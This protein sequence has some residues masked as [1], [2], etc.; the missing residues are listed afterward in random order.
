MNV[1]EQ[2][3]SAA[4][5]PTALRKAVA[6]ADIVPLLMCLV[7]LT[8]ETRYF[9][10]LRP[11][12]EG[13]WNYMQSIPDDIQADIRADLIEAIEAKVAS[14]EE[15]PREPPEDL[16]T[17]M[18][19]I[20]CGTRVPEEYM[21]VFREEA[22]FAE[23]DYRRV[24]WRQEPS[25]ETLEQFQ[26]VVVGAGFS[27]IAMA[28]RLKEAGIPYVVI[29]KNPEVGGT[30]YENTYPGIGVD[31]PCH[32]YSY[33]FAP[34]PDWS[35]YFAKGHEIHDYIMRC[36][37]QFGVRDHIRFSEEVTTAEFDETSC[38]WLVHTR[39]SGGT[40]STLRANAFV[41]AVGALN[42]PFVPDV[43]G[44]EAF[45]GPCFHT[46][47]WDHSVDLKGKKVAMI[48]TGASGMQ[49]GPSIAPEVEK[50]TIFQRSPHWSLRHPLYHSK[51]SEEV[52]WATKYIPF[53]A[54]WFR[55]QLF[56]AASDGFHPTLTMD[57]D[58]TDPKHSLNEANA[59]MREDLIAFIKQEIGD[60]TDLLPKV[61]PDYPPYG[62]RMLRENYWYQTLTR[63]NV[64]LVAGRVD[65]VEPD[66]VVHDD[67]KY[68]ADVIV[69]ATGFQAAK[70]LTPMEVV[71]VNGE[72][73]RDIWGEDD[74]RAHLG[75]TH[76]GFPNFYMIYGPNT[77]L[78]HGGSAIFHSECQVHYIMQALRE[79]IE[80]DDI[81]ALDVKREPF[82]AYNEKVDAK[83]RQM[84]WSH[85]GVTSWYKNKKGRV[86]MNSPWRL[87]DYRNFTAK[88]QTSEYRALRAAQGDDKV[89]TSGS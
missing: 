33:S 71:G 60:R 68:P 9:D 27:G 80:N 87:V 49:T 52:R 46:A 11:H 54:N 50:L 38:T 57:P 21:P 6:G 3:K 40:E 7:H 83:H 44:L 66:G 70:M 14:G 82:E 61:I 13:A 65:R 84:V 2:L 19:E 81:D 59:K 1:T 79:I 5:D 58:W 67:V 18:M 43:P 48:G 17:D 20:A 72:S 62:K 25:R 10:R 16:L 85:P 37:D 26:V 55:F 76:P 69:L 30:W 89:A 32:F 31:T 47:R 36:V 22:D 29:E 51:V 74:P 15:V 28:L 34:N 24:E 56:W 64:E 73:L 41:S 63:P 77:N 8:G 88:F 86:I 35:E 12:I 4:A 78:A 75:I 53:Y 42:K 39:K 23:K 45:E